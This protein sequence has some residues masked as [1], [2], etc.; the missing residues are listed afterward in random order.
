[1]KCLPLFWLIL[2]ALGCSFGSWK[3]AGAEKEQ[4]LT[5][6]QSSPQSEVQGNFQSGQAVF[7]HGVRLRYGEAV[8]TADSMEIDQNT[9]QVMARGKVILQR[10]KEVWE[11][12]ELSYNYKTRAIAAKRFK[13]GFPPFFA[14]GEGL[15]ADVEHRVYTA[16]NGLITTD[17]IATPFYRVEAK[18]LRAVPDEKVEAKDSVMKVGPVPLMYFPYY[19]RSLERHPNF[20]Q[21][22][23]GYRSIYGPYLLGSYHW[24]WSD[25]LNGAVHLDY[26][27]KRGVGAGPDLGF[28]LGRWGH[29]SGSLYYLHDQEPG[30]DL[31]GEEIDSDRHRIQLFYQATLRTNLTVTAVVREQSDAN[32]I[33]DFFETDYRNN[34]QPSSFL[35]VNQS[36][37]NFDLNALTMPRVNDFFQRVERLPDVRLSGFRQQLGV[38]P[39]Y[40]ESESSIGH[41]RFDPASDAGGTNYSAYRADTFHQ[42]L[43][44]QTFFGWLT[45][46]PRIGG[47]FTRYGEIENFKDD[48]NE[49]RAVFNTGAEAST[50]LS[51]V[52][53]NL[54][55]GFWDVNGLRHILE[56]SVNYVFVPN[57]T[58]PPR[59]LPQFDYDLPSF[60]L[61][62]ITFPEYN[63]IDSI[64]S[65]NVL[66]LAL[67]NKLQTKRNNQIDNLVNWAL[68]TDWRLDPRRDQHTFADVF[69]DLDYKP[70]SWMTLSSEIRFDVESGVFRLANH[71][72]TLT[73]NDVWSVSL[74]HLYF[75]PD[76]SF[77]SP[78][79]T[80]GENNLIFTRFYYR[81]NENWGVRVS[82]HFEARDGTMEEQYYTLYRDLRSWTAA[83]TFRVRDNRDGPAD[84]AVAVTFSLKAF[85]RFGLG[86]DRDKPTLLLGDG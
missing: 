6:E 86:Q 79:G 58:T 74:G 35:E 36:W 81:L 47:R 23:P 83:V 7:T 67:R 84:Y 54:Q 28:D 38:S 50:K 48:S 52:W 73:P 78:F 15:H 55:S 64:D 9:G 26:R 17:D 59:D 3:A 44:P 4:S 61:P 76:A 22:T 45:L 32:V 60:R 69:S 70:R 66:R 33:H 80:T 13:A 37:R 75:H 20:F 56:P 8:L 42:L 39:F 43:L 27:E 29:G 71:S 18:Q 11:G 12:E 68:Y 19:K 85:P 57:P 72:L 77:A 2:S 53:N 82:H 24:F 16:T 62:P 46:T 51:R 49:N 40:Y 1:M 34:P 30:K 21:L 10:G 41:F 25:Q 63:N 5:I 14:A 31:F 65:E